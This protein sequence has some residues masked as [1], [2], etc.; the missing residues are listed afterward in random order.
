MQMTRQQ[1][2]AQERA[3]AKIAKRD[4]RTRR[5]DRKRRRGSVS[6]SEKTRRSDAPKKGTE[7]RRC[8]AQVERAPGLFMWFH[9]TKGARGMTIDGLRVPRLPKP[10]RGAR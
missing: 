4:E 10:Q 8:T 9:H 1:R 5:P 6:L 3:A 7:H 2:R